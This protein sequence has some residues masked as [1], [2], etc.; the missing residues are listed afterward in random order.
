[1]TTQD[2]NKPACEATCTFSILIGLVSTEDR[3]RI[4][5][6]LEVLRSQDSSPS[7]EVILVDRRQDAVSDRIRAAYPEVRLI[8]CAAGTSLPEMR[9]MALDQARGEYVVVTEDHC[10]PT[11]DWLARIQDAFRAAAPGTAAVGGC[12]E[13]GVCDTALDWATFLC[14]YSG[15][16]APVPE[17]PARSLPGMNVAYRRS[18][19]QELDR[20]LL[21]GGFWETTVHPVLVGSGRPL[22]SANAIRILHKKRFSFRLFAGQ[23]FLYSRYYA[24]LRFGRG[25]LARRWV[26]C[27]LTLV[28]PP[29]LLVRMVRGVLAKCRLRSE[30]AFA[31]PYLTVFVV[32][33][34]AG[35]MIGY[36]LGPGDALSRI[37]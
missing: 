14:E 30:L 36:V 6:T 8:P 29:L 31:L 18:V 2:Q 35:E 4:L 24:G 27:A 9:T 12:V 15:L 17:G 16:I 13:N 3:D 22:H 20:A 37:E 21:T 26:A 32:I 33:W 1:M 25:Q 28:L 34:A 10:V 19:L 23:R 7:Y 5:E 11:Q